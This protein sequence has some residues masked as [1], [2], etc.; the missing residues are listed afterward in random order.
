LAGQTFE[1]IKVGVCDCYWKDPGSTSEVFLGLTKGGCDLTYTPTWHEIEVDQ[2]GKSATESVLIGETIKVKI[3]LAETDLDKLQMFSHT[4]TTVLDNGKKKI[5]FGRLPGFRLEG[6]AGQL[7]LHPIAMGT[8]SDEDV[9][10]YKA[11]NKAPLN[12]QYKLDAERIFATEFDGIVQRQSLADELSGAATPFLW[13]IGNP[14]VA[15][16]TAPSISLTGVRDILATGATLEFT[17]TEIGSYY[18][19]VYAAADPAPTAPT[20][21]AQGTA[22]DKGTGTAFNSANLV[23]VSNLTTATSYVAYVVVTD[24]SANQSTV[25]AIPFTTI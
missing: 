3:P 9:L 6:V 25:G 17:S 11:I 10:I 2:F 8:S 13:E 21:V 7:R 18:Y 20:V 12:L 5:T 1:T 14:L 24:T 16:I 23:N 15:D 22:I 19:L 4:A